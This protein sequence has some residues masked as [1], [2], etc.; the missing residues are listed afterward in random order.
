[1]RLELPSIA[2]VA[3]HLQP[4]LNRSRLFMVRAQD[5]A[6]RALMAAGIAVRR[7]VKTLLTQTVFRLGS[8]AG[9]HA[10][11]L[12]LRLLG[13]ATKL[14]LS[15]IARIPP[16]ASRSLIDDILFSQLFLATALGLLAIAGLW[17]ISN[18]V[19]EDNLRK[20]A[21]AWISELEDLGAPLYKPQSDDN[22]RFVRI[23]NYIANFPEIVLVRYYSAD[24]A[25]LFE[26]KPN[27]RVADKNVPA[28]SAAQLQPLRDIKSQ[29]KPYRLDTSQEGR[30][31]FRISAPVWLESMKPA[32]LLDLDLSAAPDDDVKLAGF[33]ELGLDFGGYQQRL[34]TSI[35]SGSLVLALIL[36]L[37]AVTGRYILKRMLNPLSELE[38]SLSRLA[39]G[40]TEPDLS[41]SGHKE[42]CAI[43]NA[44]RN[45]MRALHDRDKRL[46]RL[47]DYDPLTGL[48]NR[49]S[50]THKLEAEIKRV[51]GRRQTSSALLFVDLDQ[52]KYVNDTLGHAAGDR[53]LIQAASYLK[54][55]LRDQDLV[56]RFGGDEF[57]ILLR[58]VTFDEARRIAAQ[59]VQV[60][61]DALFV[62]DGQALN[63][64]CS[65]GMTMIGVDLFSADELLSQADM[66]CHESKSRGRNRYHC[67]EI[68]GSEKQRM[69]ADIGW[70]QK[71]KDALN[72][73]KFV[74]HYQPI[75][76]LK[77]NG[78]P[79]YEVLLR[80]HD[81]QQAV[82]PPAAFMPAA[83]RFGLM[84]QIDRMVIGKAL[85]ALSD[86]HKN[87]HK[88]K[89]SLNLSGY[90]FDDP[91]LVA[92]I[93]AG[94]QENN[95][96]PG[97]VIFE[98]TEQVAVRH[99]TQARSLI[100]DIMKLGCRFALDDFGAGFS[101]FN[102]L[103]NLPSDFIKIDGGF[104]KNI[105]DEPVDQAMVMSIIQI[106][107]ALGKR[108]IA[109]YVQD[110][111]TLTILRRLGVDYAQGYYIGKPAASLL[112]PASISVRGALPARDW[113]SLKDEIATTAVSWYLRRSLSRR[114]L[115]AE[116]DKRG[117]TVSLSTLSRWI[118]RH[119][120]HLGDKA[121]AVCKDGAVMEEV[122]LT[123]KGRTRFLYRSVGEDNRLCDFVLLD[124]P[125]PALAR[126]RLRELAD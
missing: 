121:A 46:R 13:T 37:L 101:S 96:D 113:R 120:D 90:V 35:I 14:H 41:P 80:M 57:A 24:G 26:Q 5:K 104:I 86:F 30:A 63:V 85:R 84:V 58:T 34:L 33:V 118:Q 66:A 16:R 55:C 25:V 6:R 100:E 103:K 8:T 10:I 64:L 12:G 76:D 112:A 110:E 44:L 124:E 77:H 19:I 52:F 97:M 79:I 123:L 38:S 62:E 65:I 73:D 20:W 88:I 98:I 78:T 82:I 75:V 116:L 42:I 15:R 18:A 125:D 50:F 117:L 56:A 54:N 95:I 89:F 7:S 45:S 102:Y 43:Q 87:G 39:S 28:L 22:E 111:E 47:A 40:D 108:T 2:P 59:L 126:R 122:A 51:G 49:R 36:A 83:N 71:I 106:A 119:A 23:E 74:L 60:M 27:N 9:R 107:N 91:D 94:L 105:V 92:L 67:Y 115:H 11:V 53:V 81:D 1:M 69:E 29:D 68:S 3:R 99:L 17:A 70:S 114:Q 93:K 61:R 32:Q 72:N 31:L 4:F 21:V 48:L 109:E